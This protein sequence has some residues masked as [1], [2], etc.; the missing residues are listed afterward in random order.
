MTWL[1]EDGHAIAG[2]DRVLRFLNNQLAGSKERKLTATNIKVGMTTDAGWAY[3][4]YTIESGAAKRSGFNT[5]VYKKTGNEWQIVL[6]H[7]AVN[8]AAHMD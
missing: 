2:K 1:D 8:A 6:V 5:T 7:G 3:F 4:L